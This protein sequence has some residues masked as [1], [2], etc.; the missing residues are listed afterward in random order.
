VRHI[1]EPYIRKTLPE[2]WITLETVWHVNPTGKFV[3]GGPDGDCGLTAGKSLSIPMA[4]RR[5]RR[6]RILWQGPDKS[7]SLGPLMPRAIRKK[8]RRPQDLL[9]AA[10][11]SF[12]TRSAFA[13]P[14]SI[15]VDTHGPDRFQKESSRKPFRGHALSPRGIREH[16]KL[17]RQFMPVRP[18]MVISARTGRRRRFSWEKTIGGEA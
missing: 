11:S 3:I 8:R 7:R 5:L 9:I 6:R 18:P 10:R 13:E 2:G 16:L 14:L 1:V 15:Y 12:P 4:G 17:N